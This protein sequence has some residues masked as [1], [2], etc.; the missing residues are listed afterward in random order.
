MANP[1]DHAATRAEADA[2]MDVLQR[3]RLVHAAVQD[4]CGR[5][6]VQLSPQAR[7]H[8][9]CDPQKVL[10]LARAVQQVLTELEADAR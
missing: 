2:W 7:V 4:P 9:L 3:F 1:P 5:W 8:L 6:L 10:D